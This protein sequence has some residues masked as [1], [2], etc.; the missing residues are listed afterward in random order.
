MQEVLTL[1]GIYYFFGLIPAFMLFKKGSLSIFELLIY[2]PG[3][4]INTIGFLI[5]AITLVIGTPALILEASIVSIAILVL[6]YFSIYSVFVV[7]NKTSK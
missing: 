3:A 4:A 7:F 6:G 2:G 1:I 5:P